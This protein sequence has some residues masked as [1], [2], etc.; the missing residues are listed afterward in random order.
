MS[1]FLQGDAALDWIVTSE[2]A[3]TGSMTEGALTLARSALVSNARLSLLAAS[4]G[5]PKVLIHMSP[6]L[7]Q[8]FHDFLE[9]SRERLQGISDEASAGRS[10]A[11]GLC[12]A[13]EE[14]G[15]WEGEEDTEP[16]RLPVCKPL[17]D[18]VEAVLGAILLDSA[19]DIRAVDRAWRSLQQCARE[20]EFGALL[21]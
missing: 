4:C 9:T 20:G 1:L 7:F 18:A 2:L 5:L 10:A 15:E 21:T 11:N 6:Q 14:V 19:W 8:L 13:G 17:A 12:E 3:A 16:S